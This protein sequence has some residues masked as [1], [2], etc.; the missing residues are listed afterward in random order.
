V[1]E[2]GRHGH[3]SAEEAGAVRRR[4]A[5]LEQTN[6][7][8]RR[9]VAT[10]ESER[11]LTDAKKV[12]G[13]VFAPGQILLAA[14]EAIAES[15]VV[16]NRSGVIQVVNRTAAEW[17][18][19][20][21]EDLIGRDCHQIGSEIMPQ[22]IRDAMLASLDRVTRTGEPVR[23]I[24]PRGGV[25]FD[26][27]FYPVLDATAQVTHVVMFAADVTTRVTAE[28]LLLES[29]QRYQDLIENVD[30]VIYTTDQ[31]GTLTGMNPAIKRIMGLDP[32]KLVGTHW[33]KWVSPE[34]F[35]RLEESRI[36]ALSGQRTSQEVALKDKEGNEHC[37]DISVGPLTA[38]GRMVGTQGIIRDI[39]EQ[40]R[41]EEEV[42]ELQ[43]QIEFI[44]GAAKTGLDIIDRDFNLRYVDPA[45]QRTYGPYEA[46]KCYE[47]FMGRDRMCPDCGIPE[48]LKTKQVNVTEEVLIR[49]G[50]RPIEVTT[51]PFQAE[52]GEWL[53][54]EVNVDITE[55]RRLERRLRENEERYRAV[56]ETAGEVIAVVDEQGIFQF[57]NSTAGKRL[58]GQP[59]DFIGR[60]MWELFP[61][62][63]ADR[64]MEHIRA[65]IHTGK[66][67]N[68][69]GLSQ[70]KGQMRWYNTTVEPLRNSDSGVGAALVIARDIHELKQASDELEAYRERMAR[71]EQ[72]ASL[73]TLSATLAH[74]LT[75]PLT[76]I[77]LCIQNVMNDLT[78]VPHPSVI[79]EDLKDVLGEISHVTAIVDRFRGFARR[80]SEKTVKEVVLSAVAQRVIRLLEESAR[81]ARIGLEMHQLQDL[82]PVLTHE[83]DIEQ[84][85]FALVQNAIQ[86]ADGTKDRS[87]R[88]IGARRGDGVELQFVDDCGGIAPANLSCIF[89][90]FFTTKPPGEGTGLGLC[91]VQRIVNQAGG[92]LRVDSRWGE[93]TT[94]SILLPIERK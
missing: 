43:R 26:R 60:S 17:L 25:F 74:E 63:V 61:A 53:V 77:R 32:K 70:V 38:A 11:G 1:G 50:N 68:S 75:Q 7:R 42:R 76:V 16:L 37:V 69:V 14:F 41:A 89:D 48:A 81:K 19:C 15:V 66:G 2:V 33:S 30:D 54:A 29:R 62:G 20:R 88:I 21:R 90:P 83:K 82:P 18:G 56:V 71:A 34:A 55:R 73:G 27:A 87:L 80:T 12:Q 92:D 13:G 49:E 22:D 72:L 8:L 45:W 86:A 24:D 23:G 78:E 36:G 85:F 5:E 4:L 46:R 79:S 44:L 28:K 94:F 51:I 52:D 91:V 35:Q 9:Q 39:T 31:E 84:V 10:L 40:K 59:S 57:M 65:V 3:R 93:G 67:E 47:Y 64:Q 58:G 6:K